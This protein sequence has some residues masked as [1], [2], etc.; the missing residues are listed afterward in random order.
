MWSKSPTDPSKRKKSHPGGQLQSGIKEAIQQGSLSKLGI[1]T[2]SKT[3]SGS[4]EGKSE[5]SPVLDLMARPTGLEPVTL[6][7][8][9]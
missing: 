3:G 8:E 6:S 5:S 7:L 1:G 9:G 2:G 4:G